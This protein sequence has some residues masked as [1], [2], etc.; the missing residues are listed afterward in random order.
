M[1]DAFAIAKT[2]SGPDLNQ[3]PE[4]YVG[5]IGVRW[6]S[7]EWIFEQ[8]FWNALAGGRGAGAAFDI[9]MGGACNDPAFDADWWGTYVWTGVAGPWTTTCRLC[10]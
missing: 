2:K 5:Y 7:D 6:D 1:P 10:N 9:A 4:F 3:G 8:R